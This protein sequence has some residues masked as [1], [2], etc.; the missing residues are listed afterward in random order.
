MLAES[1]SLLPSA[2]GDVLVIGGSGYVGSATVHALLRRGY[3]VTILDITK[4]ILD[5]CA[6][7]GIDIRDSDAVAEFLCSTKFTAVLHLAGLKNV[8]ESQLSPLDY[9]ETNVNGTKNILLGLRNSG[10]RLIFSSSCSVYGDAEETPTSEAS[11]RSPRSV[12]AWTKMMCEDMIEDWCT[13]GNGSAIVFRY[14][15]AAGAH[16]KQLYGEPTD[17]PNLVPSLCRSLLDGSQFHLFGDRF[18]TEDGSQERDFVHIDDIAL[19]HLGALRLSLEGKQV[20]FINLGSGNGTSVKSV[21]DSLE[22][23][24]KQ[25]ANV[26]LSEARVGDPTRAYADISKAYLTLGWRPKRDLAK[27]LDSAWKFAQRNPV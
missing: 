25:R 10:T 1:R 22:A 21:I 24:S 6:W 16:E 27:I 3:G 11:A 19:A 8:G 12:Y 18:A 2:R 15:N 9:L 14:F 5:E 20:E 4:P 23:L 26:I 17:S 7:V 13:A